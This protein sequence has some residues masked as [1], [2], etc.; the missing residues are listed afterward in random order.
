MRK[1][2]SVVA[3]LLLAAVTTV[4][5]PGKTSASPSGSVELLQAGDSAGIDWSKA[6]EL[7]RFEG[8]LG[9]VNSAVFSPDGK[10]VLTASEDGTA[11]LWGIPE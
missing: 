5:Q 9:D 1:C 4:A 3:L 10:Q 7:R 8:H 11:R 2:F 6:K